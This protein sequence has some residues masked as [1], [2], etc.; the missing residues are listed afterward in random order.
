MEEI[1]EPDNDEDLNVMD[2]ANMG[3]IDQEQLTA[4]EKEEQIIKNLNSNNPQAPHNIVQF[5]FK[6]RIYKTNDNVEHMV[7]HVN[8]DGNIVQ[9]ESDDHRDQQEYL[10][11]KKRLEKEMLSA[12]NKEI[13]NMDGGDP[14]KLHQIL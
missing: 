11:T 1:S 8:M 3:G 9:K 14:R 12:M 5:S 7:F 4:E 13:A 6:D 2:P 10:E